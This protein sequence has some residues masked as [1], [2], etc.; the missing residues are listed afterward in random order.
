MLLVMLVLQM[1]AVDVAIVH[2]DMT[3]ATAVNSENISIS[4]SAAKQAPTKSPTTA[5]PPEIARSSAKSSHCKRNELY[6][7]Q[8]DEDE[9]CSLQRMTEE[10]NTSNASSSSSPSS[11]CSCSN[12]TTSACA[13]ARVLTRVTTRFSALPALDSTFPITMESCFRHYISCEVRSLLMM[14]SSDCCSLHV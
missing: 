5:N 3:T 6:Q 12:G 8:Q 7:T 4:V 13:A 2:D 10:L 14:L 9:L 11:S 1:D